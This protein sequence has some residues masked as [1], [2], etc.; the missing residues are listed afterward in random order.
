MISA[1]A[2][3][4]AFYYG[5]NALTWS[6]AVANDISAAVNLFDG[7]PLKIVQCGIQGVYVCMNVAYEAN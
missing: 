3:Y 6:P 1:N 5:F 2:W 4:T 7:K